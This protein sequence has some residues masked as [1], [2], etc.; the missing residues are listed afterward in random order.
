M[1][2][3][4][5]LLAPIYAMIILLF[6]HKFSIKRRRKEEVYKYFLPGLLVKMGGAIA[7]GLIYFYYYN[8]G[9]TVNYHFTACALVDV[10]FDRPEDFLYLYFGDPQFGEIYLLN[11]NYAFFY[12]VNDSYAFFVAKCFVPISLVCFKS[13]LASAIVVAAVCYLGVWRL[14]LV[15][16]NEFPKLGKQFAWSILYIPSVVFWGSGIMK[17]SI[18]F[19]AACFYVHG[20]Y[21]FFTQKKLKAGYLFSLGVSV[22]LLLSIKPYILFA[23]LPGSII[24]YVTLRTTKMKNAVLRVMFAPTL[25]FIGLIIGVFVLQTLG[26]SLGKY[27]LEKVVNTAS[28]AQQDLKQSYYGGNTFNIGDYDASV[29]GLLSVSHKAIFAA[30][31]RPTIFD[32]RNVVMAISA[33]ENSFILGFCVYLLIKLRFFKFFGLITKHPLLMFSFIFSIFF[34]FSVG[35]SISNFGALV[36]LKIPCIPF[37]LSSLVILNELLNQASKRRKSAE[38]AVVSNDKVVFV[39]KS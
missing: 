34:A 31:F 9:D 15:F 20:F 28:G 18:T 24:W 25:V 22:Y 26:D 27:S 39:E 29:S 1:D 7:L 11:S 17:D 2:I 37:F 3:Y 16:V 30:L 13:Y 5:L 8:G 6:A 19:S 4:D 10:L 35:V 14:Y 33:I 12:W 38:N 36:R 23:L 32:V 21:W